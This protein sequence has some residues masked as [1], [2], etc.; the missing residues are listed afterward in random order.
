MRTAKGQLPVLELQACVVYRGV[1]D[2]GV[3]GKRKPE[4]C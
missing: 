4:T 2:N 3:I 1:Y